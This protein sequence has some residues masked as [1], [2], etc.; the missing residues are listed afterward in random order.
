MN[1][2]FKDYPWRKNE[3]EPGK[4]HQAILGPNFTMIVKNRVPDYI[5]QMMCAA[6]EMLAALE[7]VRK[8]LGSEGKS[9]GAIDAAI[10][11]AKGETK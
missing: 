1:D 8:V 4:Q 9:I 3:S 6:P 10:A 7:H 5:L 2:A 11:K